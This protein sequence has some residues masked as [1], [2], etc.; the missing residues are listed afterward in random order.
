VPA[1]LAA[2]AGG[3]VL[4]S[5]TGLPVL[6]RYVALEAEHEVTLLG[7]VVGVVLVLIALVELSPLASRLRLSRDR[8]FVGGIVSGFLG[9]LSGTQ[10]P[11]R[12]AVLLQA[13]LS[14]DAYVGTNVVTAVIVDVARLVV[15]GLAI[16][17]GTLVAPGSRVLPLV[18]VASLAAFAGAYLG[19][20]LMRRMSLDAVRI[21]VAALTIVVG[22]GLATGLI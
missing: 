5:L 1:A 17:F 9:G 6:V 7:V 10:G 14:R 21:A 16:P 22:I 3:A 20:R 8:L 4:A 18:V 15:Y 13:E 2:V 19:A 11:I 12:A